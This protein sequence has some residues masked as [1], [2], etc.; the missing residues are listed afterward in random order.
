MSRRDYILIADAIRSVLDQV[1]DRSVIEPI[2]H[3]IATC[4]QR[5]NPRFDRRRFVA[6]C[7]IAEA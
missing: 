4:M 7:G 5:D 3:A 6:A 2:V 1:N